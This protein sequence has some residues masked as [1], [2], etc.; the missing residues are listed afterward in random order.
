[1]ETEY[2]ELSATNPT[3]NKTRKISEEQEKKSKQVQT[4]NR[5][6]S[7]S[8]VTR[9]IKYDINYIYFEE[10]QEII[11][12]VSK[13]QRKMSN[14]NKESNVGYNSRN[15][16]LK[17]SEQLLSSINLKDFEKQSIFHRFST[18]F[19]FV[20]EKISL[21]NNKEITNLNE[22][23]K[24]IITIFLITYKLEG[25]S[26]GKITIKN[27]VQVFLNNLGMSIEDLEEEIV[28]KE[29]KILYL[30][31]Y[32]PL[33]LDNNCFKIS[34]ILFD[35]MKRNTFKGISDN[36]CV[37]FENVLCKVNKLIQFSNKLL[38]DTLPIDKAAVS[39]FTTIKY[40]IDNHLLASLSNLE[41]KKN[42]FFKYLKN[43]INVLK[44]NDDNFNSMVNHYYL[45]L[46]KLGKKDFN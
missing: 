14:Y 20:M 11:L 40:F 42:A 9:N 1:M 13:N 33:L 38:F 18:A 4:A 8:V 5:N 27:L 46:L 32:D 10:D 3:E 2:S 41:S 37:L 15:N 29:L 7:R 30:L 25:Y 23:K 36:D 17:W 39:I 22:L 43:D 21:N 28:A 26:I 31:D 6:R 24:Y 16:I 44:I 12:N 19:D 45:H 35:L 34:F